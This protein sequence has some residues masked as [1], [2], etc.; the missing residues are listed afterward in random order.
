MPNPHDEQND[1]KRCGP[2]LE[3]AERSVGPHSGRSTLPA[4]DPWDVFK[5]DDDWLEPEP[6]YGDFWEE[7]DDDCDIGR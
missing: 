7:L 4:E 2:Y 6:E 5:L 1:L 3:R